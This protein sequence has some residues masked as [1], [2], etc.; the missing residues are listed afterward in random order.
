MEL[1]AVQYRRLYTHIMK[2]YSKLF[3]IV[4]VHCS[5]LLWHCSIT[6]MVL[7][8]CRFEFV[9]SSFIRVG[10]SINRLCYKADSIPNLSACSGAGSR[11]LKFVIA[12]QGPLLRD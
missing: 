9:F 7:L 6:N 4:S 8:V 2:Y 10:I 3:V 5:T 1:V 11:L 12:V